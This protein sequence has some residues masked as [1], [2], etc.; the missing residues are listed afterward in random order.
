MDGKIV[1]PLLSNG[2][3]LINCE[4]GSMCFEYPINRLIEL[5]DGLHTMQLIAIQ[6]EMSENDPEIQKYDFTPVLR[7]I[8]R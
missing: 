5:S 8:K 3:F 4:N 6:A 1:E 7:V 2:F